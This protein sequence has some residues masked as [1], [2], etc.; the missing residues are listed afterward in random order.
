MW[1]AYT[2]IVYLILALAIPAAIA[3]APVWRKH[4]TMQQVTCPVTGTS[5]LV[6]LNPW[7]AVR[8]HALGN[9]ELRIRSCTG[10]PER[11]DCSQDCLAQ[12]EPHHP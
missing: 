3:L 5:T 6:T 2:F 7:H 1:V 11:C 12:I 4:S 10:W 8:M 9:Y